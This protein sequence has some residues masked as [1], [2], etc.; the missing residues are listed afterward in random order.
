MEKSKGW[1]FSFVNGLLSGVGLM[2]FL[3]S[4]LL[5]DIIDITT[6]YEET[7]STLQKVITTGTMPE[8]GT[9]TWV[10]P[11]TPV[12]DSWVTISIVVGI[13]LIAISIGVQ[14]YLSKGR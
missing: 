5:R 12:E 14:A 9:L 6:I 11:Q 2:C 8:N 1:D 3:I 13:I 10:I 7:V 4:V